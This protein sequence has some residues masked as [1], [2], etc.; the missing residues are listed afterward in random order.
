MAHEQAEAARRAPRRSPVARLGRRSGWAAALLAAGVVGWAFLAWLVAD[1]DH[2][3][4]QLTMPGS[5]AWSTANLLAIWLMW[6]VMMA[7]MMLPS[8]WPMVRTFV[9][10]SRR[11]GQLARGNA[12]VAA[13]LLVW[14]G[15]SAAAT[16]AQW[17]FQ[18]TDLVD[19]M[20]VSSSPLLTGALLAI[21]GLYQFSPLKRICLA[22][23]R[24]PLGF[25]LGAWRPG[26][27][28]GF[29]MGARHGVVCVGCCWALMALLFVGGAMNLAWVAALS[30][31][32]ALEKLLPGGE[33]VARLLGVLLLGI[34]A[35]KLAAT[36]WP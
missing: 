30:I 4:A 6:S 31:A 29:A 23:C 1:M 25:L 5:P 12:F 14:A 9:G 27:G 18:R 33:R 34:G 2:P 20:L 32:V 15:F 36:A 26:T 21:A 19:A 24:T 16:L 8:A 35:V 28:G 22:H 17:A 11:A 10:L 3:F 13:Y 7:A